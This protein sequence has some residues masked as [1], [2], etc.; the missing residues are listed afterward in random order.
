MNIKHIF[1]VYIFLNT[2]YV[3]S[4]PEESPPEL[5]FVLE[6]TRHGSRSPMRPLP[7]G[8]EILIPSPDQA[9][10][11]ITL[12]EYW[13]RMGYQ[14]LSALGQFQQQKVGW[15]VREEYIEKHKLLS[16]VWDPTS[17]EII[18]ISSDANRSVES[19]YAQGR[20]IYPYT[21]IDTTTVNFALETNININNI[22]Q[23]M[24]QIPVEIIP[25]SNDDFLTFNFCP[26]ALFLLSQDGVN[27]IAQ[28]ICDM[29]MH[30]N[31]I[32]TIFNLTGYT[33]ECTPWALAAL[34]DNLNSYYNLTNGELPN[35]ITSALFEDIIIIGDKIFN[36]KLEA[37]LTQI[38]ITG[39]R[40]H[41][42]NYLLT[43]IN[44]DITEK[45]PLKT[46][47]MVIIA[48]H[49]DTLKILLET[50]IDS[51]ILNNEQPTFG[52]SI[53]FEIYRSSSNERNKY[54][55]ELVYN[56]AHI[57]NKNGEDLTYTIDTLDE[58]F[59]RHVFYGNVSEWCTFSGDLTNL[60][61]LWAHFS[62]LIWKVM[63][64]LFLGII[65][66]MSVGRYCMKK[67]KEGE[68]ELMMM[69]V[70]TS[71]QEHLER[72]KSREEVISLVNRK[73]SSNKDLEIS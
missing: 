30:K 6:I 10:P 8:M 23:P 62:P 3:Q 24:L 14:R 48:G 20:G 61:I 2:S 71:D 54:H 9:E 22:H 73:D 1:L 40:E 63:S 70:S 68:E 36:Q 32:E 16:D 55:I 51:K 5:I 35:L 52:S 38:L 39:L 27:Q 15:W 47:K 31:T 7:P 19:A 11:T 53:F 17:K 18:I 43:A 37:E 50:I 57:T 72:T 28:S 64:I 21:K 58:R 26:K 46:P 4:E 34:S 13:E 60:E 59:S 67:G 66:C 42:I 49:D 69:R 45:P 65:C 56:G 33:R 44:E 41:I 12:V 29:E 25:P